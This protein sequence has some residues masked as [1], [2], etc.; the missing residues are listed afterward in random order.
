MT[1]SKWRPMTPVEVEQ[2]PGCPGVFELATLVRTV[3]FIGGAPESLSNALQQHLTVA[4]GD[5]RIPSGRL[6]FRYRAT[7]EVQQLQNDLLADYR[8]RHDGALPPGQS[9]APPAPR[10]RRHLKAV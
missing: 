10:P 2:V 9:L 6:Y 1:F 3:V 5:S 7:D 8:R 4:T